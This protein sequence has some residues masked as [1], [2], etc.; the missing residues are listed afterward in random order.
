MAG[1]GNPQHFAQ[2]VGKSGV[3]LGMGENSR[4]DNDLAAGVTLTIRGLLFVEEG[5]PPGFELGLLLCQFGEAVFEG[6]AGSGH[7][8]EP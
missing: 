4:A 6:L 8:E 7:G 2:L 1:H 3:Q 5:E